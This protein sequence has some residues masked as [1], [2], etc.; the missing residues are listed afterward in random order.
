MAIVFL[1][2]S[3]LASVIGSVC[4]IGGGILIKPVLDMVGV[5]SVSTISFLSS[6]TVLSMSLYNVGRSLRSK[7]AEIDLGTA[8]P[9]AI[10]AALGGI[11][12]S[13]CF[14]TVKTLSGNDGMIGAIQSVS[15]LILVVGTL[16]YTL[17]KKKI[18]PLY[19]KRMDVCTGIGLV[20]GALSS[21]LGIGGG[22]F[23]LVVLHYFLGL[24]T[25]RA[26]ANSLYI[27]LV[28]QVTNLLL[29][30]IKASVPEFDIMPLALMILGGICGG[31][32]GRIITEKVNN[33]VVDHLFRGLLYI[34]I[35]I[36][37]YNTVH[38]L[39]V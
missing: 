24:E 3:F 39:S 28:S 32:V 5:A 34:I 37:I 15:L 33:T 16:I 35:V 25:K 29:L 1:L 17:K 38:Y 21:F 26:A 18:V 30:F 20:L 10:G 12:G 13:Q 9:L 27:I 31:T 36:C 23:N 11:F 19:V 8:T 4:G 14:Q 6:C 2:I 7:S 22:P